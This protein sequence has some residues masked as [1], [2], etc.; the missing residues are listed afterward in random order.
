MQKTTVLP[1]EDSAGKT[2]GEVLE[3]AGGQA[4]RSPPRQPP[5]RGRL[6]EHLGQLKRFL[7]PGQAVG[8]PIAAGEAAFVL[9]IPA[10]IA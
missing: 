1:V 6:E 7:V 10:I 4:R 3:G 9:Q 2:V 8:H 5:A